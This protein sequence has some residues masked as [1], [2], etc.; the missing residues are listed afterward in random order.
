MDGFKEVLSLCD[1]V[2][3]GYKGDKFTWKIRDKKG[4]IIKERLDRFV[5]NPK[6]I[7]KMFRMEAS[8]LNYH[9]SDHKPI[10]VSME[11]TRSRI[12]SRNRPRKVR[13]EESW[14]HLEECKNIVKEIWA[15]GSNVQA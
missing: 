6:L 5:A 9:Q 12:N 14:A 11:M 7:D 2:D 4:E 8:H 3:L 13:F 15:R 1:L 10:L